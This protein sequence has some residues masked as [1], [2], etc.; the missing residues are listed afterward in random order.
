MAMAWAD[1]GA[2]A[3]AAELLLLLAAANVKLATPVVDTLGEFMCELMCDECSEDRLD[4]AGCIPDDELRLS[5]RRLPP[6]GSPG[7]DEDCARGMRW[8]CC[9]N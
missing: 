4:S 1:A 5:D 7:P 9:R 3:A 8:C 6:L 2:A